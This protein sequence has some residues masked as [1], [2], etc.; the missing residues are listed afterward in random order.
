MICK[1]MGGRV[2][3]EIVFK[4]PTTGASN[5]FEKATSIARQMVTQYGFTT[6]VGAVSYGNGGEVFLG[7]LCGEDVVSSGGEREYQQQ[8]SP[9]D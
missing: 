2:A 4:D 7:D 6:V 8:R 1:A 5:D 3:E 9:S